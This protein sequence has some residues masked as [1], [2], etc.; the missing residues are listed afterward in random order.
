MAQPCVPAAGPAS[1]LAGRWHAP[2]TPSDFTID[3]VLEGAPSGICGTSTSTFP[4][5]DAGGGPSAVISG[6]E[7]TLRFDYATGEHSEQN[8]VRQDATH[9]TIGAQQFV[10]Q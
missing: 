2:V 9:V 8:V 5:T 10:R 4:G 3:L 1:Y 6:N 7:Q